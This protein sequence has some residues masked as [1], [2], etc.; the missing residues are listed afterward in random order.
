MNTKPSRYTRDELNRLATD[1]FK[2]VASNHGRDR[3]VGVGPWEIEVSGGN[4]RL[5]RSYAVKTDNGWTED[6]H[7]ILL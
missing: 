5:I 7:S 1:A 6:E 4:V 2:S 3:T